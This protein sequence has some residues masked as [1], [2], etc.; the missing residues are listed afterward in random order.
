M[1]EQEVP[2]DL[3]LHQSKSID[4]P[5]LSDVEE[6]EEDADDVSEEDLKRLEKEL[7][8]VQN[9]FDRSMVEKHG[10]SSMCQELTLKLKLARSLL[11]GLVALIH[12][13]V[14]LIN[15]T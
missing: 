10:L 8:D 9:R 6:E 13:H 1:L 7:S 3:T 12:V 11:E 2:L 5:S 15:Y 14:C 4:H